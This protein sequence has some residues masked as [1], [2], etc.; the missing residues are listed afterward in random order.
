MAETTTDTEQEK[1]Q[2]W[3]QERMT[4]LGYGPEVAEV[5]ALAEVDWHT[6][7]DLIKHGCPLDLAIRILA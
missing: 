3:R 2:T 7:D 4:E 5:C 1:V 6:L